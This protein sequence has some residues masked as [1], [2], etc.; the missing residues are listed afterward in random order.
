MGQ[1]L[2]GNVG[3]VQIKITVKGIVGVVLENTQHILGVNVT[4]TAIINLGGNHHMNVVLQEGVAVGGFYLG[5]DV[6][7]ILTALD[8]NLAQSL[9]HGYRVEDGGVG[10]IGH[11]TGDIVDTFFIVP[12]GSHPVA[13]GFVP[14]FEL[15][16]V[17]HSLVLSGLRIHI[18][19]QLGQVDAEGKHMAVIH[20]GVIVFGGSAL[21]GENHLVVVAV[22]TEN[23]GGVRIDG[24]RVGD[25]DGVVG[26]TGIQLAVDIF[27]IAVDFSQTGGSHIH[28]HVPVIA[29]VGDGKLA[30]VHIP[31]GN[32]VGAVLVRKELNLH[33]PQG[34]V[35]AQTL[36]K[37]V[38]EV[39]YRQSGGLRGNGGQ[40]GNHL[41]LHHI[42]GGA[43]SGVGKAVGNGAGAFILAGVLL[44]FP[45]SLFQGGDAGFVLGVNHHIVI[46]GVAA[47]GGSGVFVT[48]NGGHG[49][50]DKEGIGGGSHHFGNGGFHAQIQAH[51]QVPLNGLAVLIGLGHD[52]GSILGGHV[53]FQSVLDG[54]GVGGQGSS[55]SLVQGFRGVV[56]VVGA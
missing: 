8:H 19:E 7:V 45:D 14:D 22:V 32:L 23:H 53:G 17:E 55:Q 18:G 44:G 52:D 2:L 16:M 47:L 15:H 25:P 5:D 13:V 30:A 24:G 49:Q 4:G 10:F 33:I 56:I 26:V 35:V 39:V 3:Q 51:R 40:G 6:L 50:A 37:G 21:P 36:T 28:G 9:T 34:L 11:M 27:R 1:L 20:Q 12:G 43:G 38:I 42:T 29:G 54:G 46:P 48:G 31:G 41:V